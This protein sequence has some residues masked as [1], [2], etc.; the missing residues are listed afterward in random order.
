L[1]DS[2][3]R[4]YGEWL[5]IHAKIAIM[6]ILETETPTPLASC[7]K[8]RRQELGLSYS[9]LAL[10]LRHRGIQLNRQG[11][12]LWERGKRSYS[13]SQE[14]MSLLAEAMG[15]SLQELMVNIDPSLD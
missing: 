4:L 14:Q 15:W 11:I 7:V 12:S 1:R 5:R 8:T 2:R 3:M 13:F 6:D 9:D 10:R